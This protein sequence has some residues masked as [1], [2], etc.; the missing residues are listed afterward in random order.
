MFFWGVACN[1]SQSLDPAKLRHIETDLWTDSEWDRRGPNLRDSWF[2][3]ELDRWI[4]AISPNRFILYTNIDIF[5]WILPYGY[6]L[7][8]PICWILISYHPNMDLFKPSSWLIEVSSPRSNL[9]PGDIS[10]TSLSPSSCCQGLD[11]CIAPGR[12]TSMHDMICMYIY[13]YI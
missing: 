13:I 7:D 2:T 5:N 3:S 12:R 8:K 1:P 9:Q 10:A 6:F 11:S 4:R